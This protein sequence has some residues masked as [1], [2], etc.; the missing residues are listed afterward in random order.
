[1][2]G[3]TTATG[4]TFEIDS[5]FQGQEGLECVLR[6]QAEGRPYALA[7]VDVRMPP[8]WDGVETIGHL[9]QADPDL[10]I[11]I[12]TA[13]SDYNWSDISNL[14][15]VSHSLVV[16][17][18]PFDIIEVIQL[19]HAM[20]AKWTSMLHCRLQVEELDRLVEERTSKLSAANAQLKLLAAA[21]EAAAN[22]VSITDSKGG[23]VWT[24]PA[25]SALSGYSAEEV[26]GVNRSLLKSGVQDDE[27]YKAL[28]ET[29]SS[30]KSVARRGSQ[31]SQRWEPDRRRDDD[32]GGRV[33][34]RHRHSLHCH[35]SGHH[36]TENGG[37]GSSR[38]QGKIPG[39]L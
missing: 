2:F 4:I 26:L 21:L 22:S 30:G 27:F 10:Q 9:W 34:T 11:V 3:T 28:W 33:A 19:A 5:A 13:H 15:G 24:N 39:Y 17:K 35:Q 6:A 37:G 25:F 36:G 14:L 18:K 7:F 8:G 31:S 1:L 23:F 12:C 32:H 38:G 16:L 20:T 29:I